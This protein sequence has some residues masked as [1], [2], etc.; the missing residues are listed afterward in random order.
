MGESCSVEGNRKLEE[1]KYVQAC[2]E[3]RLGK[4]VR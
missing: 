2:V 3:E 4:D 1:D